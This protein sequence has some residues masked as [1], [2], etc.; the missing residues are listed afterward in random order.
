MYRRRFWGGLI[1]YA[2]SSTLN[3]KRAPLRAI[4]IGLG[5]GSLVVLA[6]VGE[7]S[8]LAL[9]ACAG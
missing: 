8:G 9:D 4:L 6:A 2:I 7:W 3:R 5:V 1:V